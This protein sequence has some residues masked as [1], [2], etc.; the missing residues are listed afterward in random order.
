MIFDLFPW[1]TGFKHKSQFTEGSVLRPFS[2]IKMQHD[3][4]QAEEKVR[5]VKDE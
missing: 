1:P 5:R 4:L 2:Y 3:V